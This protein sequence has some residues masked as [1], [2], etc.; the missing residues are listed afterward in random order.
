M[1]IYLFVSKTTP[2]LRAFT[3]DPGGA[4]LP[5]DYGPWTFMGHSIPTRKTVGVVAEAVERNGFFLLSGIQRDQ[6]KGRKK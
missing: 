1:A 6:Q 4:N 3:S 5:A 2:S